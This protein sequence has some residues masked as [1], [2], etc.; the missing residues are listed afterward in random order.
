MGRNAKAVITPTPGTLT[1]RRVVS[2][3]LAAA[4]MRLSSTTCCASTSLMHRQ[5]T[6]DDR[7]QYMPIIDELTDASAELAADRPREQKTGFLEQAPDLVLEVPADADQAG[8]VRARGAWLSLLLTLTSRYQ[9]TRTSSAR[10][11]HHWGRSCSSGR[12]APYAHDVRHTRPARTSSTGPRFELNKTGVSDVTALAG[13]HHCRGH[14][15]AVQARHR[16]GYD[17]ETT[18]VAPLSS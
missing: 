15:R 7:T 5:Q 3:A 8:P 18:S 17:F 16:M 12:T 9:P 4:R 6:V 10:H 13:S 1:S 11:R 14:H 2:S